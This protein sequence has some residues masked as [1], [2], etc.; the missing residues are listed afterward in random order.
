MYVEKDQNRGEAM[1]KVFRQK[2]FAKSFSPKVFCRKFFVKSF[3]SKV[4]CCKFFVK[5]FFC[6]KFFV[7]SFSS[8]VFRRKISGR[9]FLVETLLSP[10]FAEMRRTK[11]SRHQGPYSET[12]IQICLQHCQKSLCSSKFY[13]FCC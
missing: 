6:R 11:M 13:H 4:F 9:K 3:L 2:F 12:C 5:S 7:K 10:L 1:S 8:K